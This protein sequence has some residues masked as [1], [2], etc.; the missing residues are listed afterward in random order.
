MDVL[1]E[2]VV[3]VAY[4]FAGLRFP[5]SKNTVDYESTRTYSPGS[6]TVP[7]RPQAGPGYY[8]PMN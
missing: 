7:L 4:V 6:Q 3:V 8:R 2:F 1:M 5:V